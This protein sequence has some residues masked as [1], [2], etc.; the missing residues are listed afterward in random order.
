M[1]LTI[2]SGEEAS[3]AGA[4]MELGAVRSLLACLL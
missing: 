4:A 3:P 1:D 2:E